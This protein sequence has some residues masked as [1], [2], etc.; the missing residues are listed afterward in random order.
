MRD[1]LFNR[2]LVREALA[3]R[4][5]QAQRGGDAERRPES[6]PAPV[7]RENSLIRQGR[8]PQAEQGETRSGAAAS[9]RSAARTDLAQRRGDPANAALPEESPDAAELR[10]LERLLAE[11]PDDPGSL[12]ANRFARQLRMRGTWHHDTGARW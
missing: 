7:R 2:A 11:V 4:R 5:A 3:K 8:Q 12:L 1:A 10:R 9:D 6:S